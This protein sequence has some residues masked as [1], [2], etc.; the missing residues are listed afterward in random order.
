MTSIR[1][2]LAPAV[3]GHD[4]FDIAGLHAKMNT[5]L[6]VGLDPGQPIAKCAID[7]AV[8][9]LIGKRLGITLQ[10]WL[11]A[12]RA[13]SVPLARLVSGRHARRGG[14]ASRK[15]RSPRASAASR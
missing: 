11:G 9:D 6:A 8:H 13:D 15:R 3:I 7:L 14:A 1:H 12:K 5:E 2:Y 10:S 4:L